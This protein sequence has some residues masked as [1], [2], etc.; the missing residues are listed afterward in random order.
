MCDSGGQTG[1]QVLSVDVKRSVELIAGVLALPVQVP[2]QLGHTVL[3][4]N[5]QVPELHR[6]ATIIKTL[7]LSQHT[8]PK[9]GVI[10]V[11]L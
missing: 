5:S 11:Y 10:C 8:F 9:Q 3:S 1:V 2:Q 7:A 4:G 6:D